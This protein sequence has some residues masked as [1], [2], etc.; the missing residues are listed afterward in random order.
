MEQGTTPPRKY[1]VWRLRKLLTTTSVIW[2]IVVHAFAAVGLALLAAWALYQTGITNDPGSVDKNSRQI[3]NY[4]AR[5]DLKDTSSAEKLQL[6]SQ[7]D[8][9]IL[10]KL[11]PTNARLIFEA[12]KHGDCP[13]A[14]DRMTHVLL[15]YMQEEGKDEQYRKMLTEVYATINKYKTTTT[16]RNAIPWM[17]EAAWPYL[18]RA[19]ID[20]QKAVQKAAEITGVDAR[21]IVACTVGEQIRL[22]N[23]NREGIKRA[24]GPATM[25]VNSQFSFG[26][27]GIKDF[28]AQQVESNLKN[29]GSKFYMGKKYESILNF[30]TEDIENE[31]IARLTNSADHLYSYIYTGCILH[32]SM[33]Q[34]KRAGFDISDRPDILFTL[35]NLG[36]AYSK[37]HDNP[38]CGGANISVGGRVYTFGALCNDFFFSG[39]LAKEFPLHSNYFQE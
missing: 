7:L 28:T 26:V 18:Q 21:L 32:Q 14:I 5:V 6:Q 24:L 39:A 20:D 16:K 1:S 15:P 35:F 10:N 8:L 37:P 4:Q 17:N 13:D 19:L 22:C 25:M 36:F 27:N 30:E 34:W 3:A 11:Y 12:N 2:Q 9:I 23:S 29:S 31:R 33:L 38:Q